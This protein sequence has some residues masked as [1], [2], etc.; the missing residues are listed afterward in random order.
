M[1]LDVAPITDISSLAHVSPDL[2]AALMRHRAPRLAARLGTKPTLEQL[3]EV[4]RDAHGGEDEAHGFLEDLHL[5]ARVGAHEGAEELLL[6]KGLSLSDITLG[7]AL[8]HAAVENRAAFEAVVDHATVVA[9]SHASTLTVFS[10]CEPRD[11]LEIREGHVPAVQR[12]C[13][14]FFDE[15]GQ[16]SHCQVR[17]YTRAEE[18][19]FLIDHAGARRTE[20]VI[21]ER[22]KPEV[23]RGRRFR[24][25][26]VLLQ[27]ES[28]RLQILAR[29]EKER[30]FYANLVSR[31]LV[32][33]ASYFVPAEAYLLDAIV[34][35]DYGSV[36][37]GL[38]DDDI[39]RIAL[40]QLK[41][42]GEDDF[43]TRH[44]LASN[45]VLGS[46]RGGGLALDSYVAEQ[47]SFTIVPRIRKGRR[48]Y[49]LTVW[50][51]NRIRCDAP[52]SDQVVHDL[53]A[54]LRLRRAAA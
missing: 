16:G 31:L 3:A 21:N 17:F 23:R 50:K 40:R 28:G 8:A 7:D 34:D 13:A 41:M 33:K 27:R 29:S 43:T 1:R 14:A 11:D 53:L 20:L 19:G 6:D 37:T 10:P 52:W 24:H 51:G 49:H 25:D 5:I 47:A 45:D 36:L 9:A 48:C 12:D 30:V 32:G 15:L 18:T 35:P 38:V 42:I 4:I 39:E 26:I 2:L 44:V 54:R 46:L 22:E